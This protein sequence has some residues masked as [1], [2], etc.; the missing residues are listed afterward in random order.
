MEVFI[1]HIK[2]SK[3]IAI[4]PGK[5]GGIAVFSV[6]CNEIIS[7][8]TMPETPQDLFNFLNR[9]R[10]NSRCYVERVGG[11]PGM[12][13]SAMFNFGRGFG[14]LEMALVACKIPT[15]EVTPQKWQK[16]L[17]LGHKGKQSTNEWKTKLKNI[18]QQM[19]PDV[20]RKFNL[21][22]KKDWLSVS[23]ALLILEYARKIEIRR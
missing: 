21:K 5:A 16:D 18:A 19:Y 20:E 2:D 7:L 15:I 8:I 12:G 9:Y 22:T 13:A 3:I 11:I 14:H 17:Q 10:N 1:K 6:D 23:D 4:D